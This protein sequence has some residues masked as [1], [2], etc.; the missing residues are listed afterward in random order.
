MI[1]KVV[2]WLPERI[3][4]LKLLKNPNIR[5]ARSA[6]IAYRK[7]VVGASNRLT[8]GEGSIVEGQLVFERE[9]GEI[10][11]GCNT[12]IGG[13]MLACATRIEVGDDVLI[14]WGCTIVDH[15][16]HS[17]KWSERQNDVR[18]WYRGRHKKDWTN[19]SMDQV[20]IGDKSWLGLNVVVLKG[21]VIG[22]GAIVGAGSVVTK[23]VPPWAIAVGNPARVIRQIPVE[24]R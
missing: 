8:I 13:S 20:I 18:D 24:G 9:V 10:V 22:E 5:I 14:S 12:A 2:F 19:V 21:V 16:S 23:S 6:K 3:A 7:L 4:K 11:I 15:N 1:R 17:T